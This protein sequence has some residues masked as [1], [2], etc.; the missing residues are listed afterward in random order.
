MLLL[1]D[2]PS[3]QA[4]A[5][6]LRLIRFQMAPQVAL[7]V[8]MAENSMMETDKTIRLYGSSD[9]GVDSVK[10]K[11]SNMRQCKDQ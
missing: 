1:K 10:A 2:L 4:S 3:I 9:S 7:R 11:T 8:D 5:R 6:Q